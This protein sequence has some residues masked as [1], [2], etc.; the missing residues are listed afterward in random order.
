LDPRRVKWK[1]IADARSNNNTLFSVIYQQA[2][3]GPA[4]VLVKPIWVTGGTDPDT[5]ELVPGCWDRQRDVCELPP[6]PTLAGDLVSY[7]TVDPSAAKW[8]CIQ[9]WVTR[10]VD[11]VPFERYLM[12]LHRARMMAPDLLDWHNADQTHGG[13]MEEWQVRSVQLKLPITHW[14]IERN[15]AQRYLLQYEHVKRWMS[16]HRVAIVPHDTQANKADPERG[17]ESLR[18]IWHWG[19]VR[20]PGKGNMTQ[21]SAAAGGRDFIASMKLVEEVTHWPD[22][23]TTDCLMSEWFGEFWLPRSPPG[24]RSC[25]PSRAPASWPGPIPTP[26][27]PGTPGWHQGP[28]SASEGGCR[29]ATRCGWSADQVGLRRQ[30][31][32]CR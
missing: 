7:A 8:W 25:P 24:V 3:L 16:V 9:W 1:D 6:G 26:G 28:L 11:G 29:S 27:P 18:D 30:W 32:R 4:D 31:Q 22:V 20:L 15:G 17:V 21:R 23:L 5:G 13:L 14:V 12:D 2:D 10:C 19:L